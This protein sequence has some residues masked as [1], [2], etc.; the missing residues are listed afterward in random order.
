MSSQPI[1]MPKLGLTMTEGVIA[2]WR[3]APGDRVAAGDVIF[4]VETEK[5]ANEVEA[6]EAGVIAA[7]QVEAGATAQV[8]DILAT[9]AVD[10]AAA[11]VAHLPQSRASQAK[12]QDVSPRAPADTQAAPPAA[13]RSERV[14]ATPLARRVAS[15]AGIKLGTVHGS[16]P[17]QRIVAADV[18][19]AIAAQNV[20]APAPAAPHSAQGVARPLSSHQATVAKRLTQAKQEIPHFYIFAEPD[21]TALLRLRAE[22]NADS[23][24]QKLSV[25]HFVL[26]A[27]A[28]A[29]ST[30]PEINTVWRGGE[31]VTLPTAD[32]GFAVETPKGLFAP[33]LRDAGRMGLDE[34]ARAADEL[35]E[36][37]RGGRLQPDDLV[38]GAISVSNVGMFGATAVLPIINPGQS[39]ILGVGRSRRSFKPDAASAPV[40]ADELTLALSCDH[41]VMDG[42]AAAR[43]LQT[44]QNALESP[45][46][47]LRGTPSET[48]HR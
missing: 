20:A 40:I 26:A 4:V 25:N 15:Q 2:E 43:F 21:V 31:L 9:L 30:A 44:I 5:I 29:L 23:R 8:G 27:V 33:V 18:H 19:A 6:A 42:G 35:S 36:R 24:Y 48:V 10:G 39:S 12:P 45:V 46:A 34:L 1:T 47:L 16:G 17:R 28:R 41:R 13:H 38:G 3:V 7:I 14:V 11:D 22:L 32:V 37:A